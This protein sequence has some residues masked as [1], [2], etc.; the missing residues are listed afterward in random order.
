MWQ[1]GWQLFLPAERFG[2]DR[3]R[4]GTWTRLGTGQSSMPGILSLPS[5][6]TRAGQ[7]ANLAVDI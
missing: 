4:T 6:A 7:L 2:L 1:P 3:G 5:S